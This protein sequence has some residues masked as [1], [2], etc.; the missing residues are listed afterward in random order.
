MKRLRDVS[1]SKQSLLLFIAKSRDQSHGTDGQSPHWLVDWRNTN[2][3]LPPALKHVT[4]AGILAH[5]RFYSHEETHVNCVSQLIRNIQ[6][7]VRDS[8]EFEFAARIA[9]SF[10]KTFGI[11]WTFFRVLRNFRSHAWSFLCWRFL[12]QLSMYNHT[13][14]VRW[15][16]PVPFFFACR[17]VDCQ[18]SSTQSSWRAPQW[19]R[20]VTKMLSW[21]HFWQQ[22]R[23]LQS[24]NASSSK[25]PFCCD[26]TASESRFKF[27]RV[28]WASTS[29]EVYPA[30][31]FNRFSMR[32]N[33]YVSARERGRRFPLQIHCWVVTLFYS[34]RASFFCA[35]KWISV[36]REHNNSPICKEKWCLLKE[37]PRDYK[38]LRNFKKRLT[39]DATWWADRKEQESSGSLTRSISLRNRVDNPRLVRSPRRSHPVSGWIRRTGERRN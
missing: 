9:F 25:C 28:S 16:K 11:A 27:Q 31:S 32:I 13:L 18:I 33:C 10:R 2:H 19:K 23:A 17:F 34:K 1:K 5:T 35:R 8:R 14:I 6:W 7:N 4:L 37:Q 38:L 15:G 24:V 20:I 21:P 26:C 3:A 39:E 36:H 22:T 29:R 30:K 12:F